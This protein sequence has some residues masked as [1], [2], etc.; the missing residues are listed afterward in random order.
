MKLLVLLHGDDLLI[1]S[2]TVQEL[3]QDFSNTVFHGS[4]FK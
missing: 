2:Y 3:L 4:C 1:P